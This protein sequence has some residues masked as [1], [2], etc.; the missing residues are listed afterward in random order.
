[1]A[2][3]QAEFPERVRAVVAP[4]AGHRVVL[5]ASDERRFGLRTIRRR[6][7][8]RCGRK[9]VGVLQH[10]YRNFWL[11][12]AVAP[13][14][15]DGF[16]QVLPTLD[17]AQMQVLLNTFAAAR[18]T[19]LNVLLL[20]NSRAHTAQ[21][22]IVPPN[23]VLLFQPAYAPELNPS[24]RVWEDLK[25]DLAWEN[26]PSLHALQAHIVQLVE[27]YDAPTLQ[28]LTAYPYFMQAVNGLSP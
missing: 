13:A 12:G 19:T 26:Y 8:T 22:L 4:V 10:G 25:T 7:I 1:V 23:V 11:Y 15:G 3:F 21:D 27:A 6:R 20:D 28:S 9:P 2:A 24:E 5:W 18:P 16:F 17:S 14:T